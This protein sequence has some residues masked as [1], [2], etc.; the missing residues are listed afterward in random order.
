MFVSSVLRNGKSAIQRQSMRTFASKTTIDKSHHI[1]RYQD[2]CFPLGFKVSGTHCG[3]KKQADRK[4]LGILVNTSGNAC[5]AAACFTKNVFKAAPVQVSKQVLDDGKGRVNGFIVN[6][7]CANAVTGG[8]GMENAWAMSK[9]VDAASDSNG[10][11][12]M[13]TGV[14]GQHLPIEK[15]TAAI[16]QLTEKLSSSASAWMD[17]ASAFM[18]TDTFPKL[19]AKEF[20]LQGQTYR[21]VGIDKGAGMIHPNMA[22]HATLLG[23]IATDAPVEPKSLTTALTHAVDRSFNSISV[24]GDMSTNDTILCLANGAAGGGKEEITESSNPEAFQVF[25]DEL[26]TFAQDLAQLV[27]RDG[28][29]ATKFV[30]IRVENGPSYEVAKKVASSVATSSLVKTAFYGQDANWGRILCAVGYTDLPLDTISPQDV[31]VSFVPPSTASNTT[32]LRLLTNGEPEENIDE[33]RAS[34]ILAEQDLEVLID[35]GHKEGGIG[36][37]YWTCDFS[38]VSG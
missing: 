5:S 3:I 2:S 33:A 10:T 28:E 22:P 34:E 17:L 14:I 1:I 4:D 8:K 30:T 26:T 19:R 16:P 21:F 11:L 18:T 9:A 37:K 24:D 12:V 15:I 27:V 38:H 35:L 32:P 20:Q 36:A 6:S 31:C 23:V 7:G 25:Q 29:G 13:S